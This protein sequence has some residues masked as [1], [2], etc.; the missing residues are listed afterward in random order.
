M[1]KDLFLR[2]DVLPRELPSLFSNKQIYLKFSQKYLENFHSK[3][4]LTKIPTIPLSFNIPK[5][6]GEVR[7]IGLLHPLAQ[8]QAFNYILKYEQLITAFC[9]KSPYSVRSPIKRNI[10]KLNWKQKREKENKK[11]EQEFNFD[12]NFTVT[13]DEDEIF[14]L[15]YFSYNKYKTL[16]SMY[17]SIKFKRDKYKY[18]Y[19]MK[20]DIQR[21]FP[22]IYTHALSWAIFGDKS[23]AKN[24]I[25]ENT[26]PYDSDKI[27]QV[28]NFNET[29]G[30][31]VGPEFS[32]IMAELLLTRID[33]S[34]HMKL[35]N[36]HLI[37]KKNYSI[38]RFIDDYFIFANNKEELLTIENNLK[39]ELDNYNLTLN[40]SKKNLQEKPFAIHNN[41]IIELK[42]ILNEFNWEKKIALDKR[43]AKDGSSISFNDFIGERNQWNNLM[44][45]LEQLIVKYPDSKSRI[46]NYF[47]KSIR[48]SIF[49]NGKHKHVIVNILEIVGNI[50]TL[51]INYNSTNY[52]IAI[53]YKV[54]NESDE[55]NI[56]LKNYIDEKIFQ[57]AFNILKNNKAKLNNMFDMLIFMKGLDKK[58]S[59]SFL[60]EI[61]EKYSDSYFICCNIAKYILNEKSNEVYQEYKTVLIKLWKVVEHKVNNYIP[62]GAQ[63]IIL[64]SEY[65]YFLNDFSKYPGFETKHSDELNKILKDGLSEGTEG[66]FIEVFKFLTTFSY[67]N[68][69]E[70]YIEF[71]KK[72]VKKSSNSKMYIHLDY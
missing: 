65:F 4:Q 22:S 52:L 55:I 1:K 24:K 18:P 33:A 17:E 44:E 16:S 21:C 49:F 11:I 28:I 38:Y 2:T 71:V 45:K 3:K 41:S 26:F 25:I 34:L 31:V 15:N 9:Q 69:S 13:S 46:V 40:I 32:R 7:T 57:N 62:Q 14:F 8:I 36:S 60:C 66:A 47:L 10:P 27:S 5:S 67:Y 54:L 43:N 53:Y 51:D 70:N 61:L 48:S 19:F 63:H 64:E 29:H 39:A 6:N 35:K 23:L 50:F 58:L 42:R 37:H 20:L 59:S 56:T 12:N 30:I 68:W 72:I